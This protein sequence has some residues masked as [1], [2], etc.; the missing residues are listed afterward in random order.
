MKLIKWK[1]L[2]ITCFLCLLPILLGISLWSKLPDAVAIHFNFS[3]EPDNFASKPFAVFAL[4]AIM[5]FLQGFLCIAS[6]VNSHKYKSPT[7]SKWIIPV[8]S[9]LLQAA[10]LG[11]APG[12]NIDMRKISVF[13]VGAVLL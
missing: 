11:Y 1:T 6:D 5:A 12:Q 7:V 8:M 13:I 3:G 2:I 4:P 9:L 10:T